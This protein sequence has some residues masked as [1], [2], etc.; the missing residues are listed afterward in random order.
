MSENASRS[1]IAF[2]PFLALLSLL[3]DLR[4]LGNSLQ[5][6]SQDLVGRILHLFVAAMVIQLTVRHFALWQPPFSIW[7]SV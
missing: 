3:G 7:V 2:A 6:S 4:A 1:S 5:H